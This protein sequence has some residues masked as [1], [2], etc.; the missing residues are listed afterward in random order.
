MSHTTILEMKISNWQLLQETCKAIGAKCTIGEL[1]LKLFSDKP[2]DVRARIKLPGWR[3]EIGVSAKGDLY[4]D[5]F[6][7]QSDTMKHL[8]KLR[9]EYTLRV[10]EKVAKKQ[11]RR[12][13][14][15]KKGV[16][17][18]WQFVEVYV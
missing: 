18:G 3:Y 17:P 4:Y 1:K 7:S 13:R 12:C 9:N 15:I 6:G 5:N 10:A 14:R 2:Y 16:R 11:K 8:V